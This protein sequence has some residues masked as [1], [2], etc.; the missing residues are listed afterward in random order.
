M[1][2]MRMLL[3]VRGLAGLEAVRHPPAPLGRLAVLAGHQDPPRRPLDHLAQDLAD[4][5]GLPAPVDQLDLG[6]D[7]H[8]L[9]HQLERHRHPVRRG[10]DLSGKKMLP[11]GSWTSEPSSLVDTVG[12]VIHY[13]G[14][15]LREV[16]LGLHHHLAH[17]VGGGGAHHQVSAFERFGVLLKNH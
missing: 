17:G 14:R 10:A 7:A 11:E 15:V 5:A 1:T 12:R 4:H 6:V 8:K 9:E 3:P 16:R 2:I 13:D